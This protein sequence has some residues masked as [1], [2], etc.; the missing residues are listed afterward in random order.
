MNC[1]SLWSPPRIIKLPSCL[2][3]IFLYGWKRSFA[4]N[5]ARAQ[6]RRDK[7]DS[8]MWRNV[9]TPVPFHALA[10]NDLEPSLEAV[11]SNT[12]STFICSYSWQH[13]KKKGVRIPGVAPIWR[14]VSLPVTVPPD[15]KTVFTARN[16]PQ[17]PRYYFE[18]L[19]RAAATMNPSVNFMDVDIVTTRNSLRKL[20][21]FC[22]GVGLTSF[23]V[24]LSMIHNTLFIERFE[25]TSRAIMGGAEET[26]Y[27]SS[28]EKAST[29]LPREA[30][31]CVQYHRALKYMLGELNCVVSF[32]VDAFYQNLDEDGK[33]EE[34]ETTNNTMLEEL[35]S[36]IGAPGIR[37]DTPRNEGMA[38]QMPTVEADTKLTPQSA[39]AE[40]KT[41]TKDFGS[42]SRH[43]PQLWFGRTPWLI[44]ARHSGG[45]FDRILIRRAGDEF[46]AWE[47]EHQ[48]ELRRLVS[49]LSQLR[50]VV[51]ENGSKRCIGIFERRARDLEIN[52]FVSARKTGALAGN[53]ISKFWR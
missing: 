53:M 2:R 45:T 13:S 42:F 38:V 9:K 47:E 52:L 10:K 32:E 34:D 40:I 35:A 33:K 24:D 18:P 37:S 20:F 14:N 11:S 50:E 19:F 17:A 8:W 12:T 41:T 15:S 7:Q 22:G 25:K 4:S 6:R 51:K 21:A 43:L 46:T 3:A 31:N 49:L 27:G 29:I 44:R 36:D 5:A 28:F 48:T 39:A 1:A 30:K 26:G 23:R 16:L